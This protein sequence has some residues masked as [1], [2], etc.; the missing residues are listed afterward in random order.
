MHRKMRE[1]LAAID[2]GDNGHIE[3][4]CFQRD[5]ARLAEESRSHERKHSAETRDLR[6]GEGSF[7]K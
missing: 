7:R 2:D 6:R 3:P 5:G 1:G 4:G